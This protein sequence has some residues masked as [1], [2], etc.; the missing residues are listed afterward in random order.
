MARTEIV[1][2][3]YGAALDALRLAERLNP[4]D[5]GA[6]ARARLAYGYGLLGEDQD[7]RRL[8]VE[9][10][11]LADDQY[12]DP[13]T[14]ALAYMSV[15]EYGEALEQFSKAAEDLRLIQ[16]PFTANYVR[17]NAWGDPMLEELRASLER[18]GHVIGHTV[19]LEH[20]IAHETGI[21]QGN[22]TIDC[23]KYLL[24][25]RWV[26]KHVLELRERIGEEVTELMGTRIE[27]VLV[28][29]P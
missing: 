22:S 7:A 19:H 5:V 11:D 26:F 24:L 13:P 14:W 29:H 18:L 16:N 15:G 25:H 20:P 1:L 17:E 4:D 23:I 3:N 27:I 12:V 28:P 10:T 6:D 9:I 21:A 2:G 8:F